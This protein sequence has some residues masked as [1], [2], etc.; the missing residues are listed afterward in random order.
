MERRATFIAIL[1]IFAAVAICY[2]STLSAGFIWD[3]QFLIE[4]NPILRAPLSSLYIFKQ[5]IANSSGAFTIYYRPLQ[6]LSYAIDYRTWGI[7]PFGF[8]LT[9]ILL[10]FLN[11]VCT[12]FL[13]KKLT[14]RNPIALLTAIFFA[15]HPAHAGVVSY[16]SG[17]ADLLLFLFAF[18]SILCFVL[19]RERKKTAYLAGSTLFFVAALLSK[20]IALI[21]PILI[22]LTDLVLLRRT[23]NNR[24][25]CHVPL[26]LVAI[27]YATCHHYFFGNRY[28]TLIGY[29]AFLQN[30]GDYLRMLKE[31]FTLGII[32][33]GSYMR[34]S[35]SDTGNMLT[36]Y[37]AIGTS[38]SILIYCLKNNRKQ[39]AYSLA[40]FFI[41]L[42]PLFFVVH[43]FRV[44]ADHWMYV[45]S[46]G[47]FFF[48]ALA[49]RG[50]YKSS[51]NFGKVFA[52]S[53]ITIGVFTF[54]IVTIQQNE[55]WREDSSLS[56]RI[57]EHS[58]EDRAALHYKAVST[59][60]KGEEKQ[61]LEIAAR[62]AELNRHDPMPWYTKGRLE[63]AADNIK[64]ART[65]FQTAIGINPSYANGYLGLAFVS[66]AQKNNKKGIN[67]LKK[68]LKINPSHREALMLL[69]A[70]Y[71]S[72]ED[73]QKA[74]KTA[75]RAK[76][77]NPYDYN[78][79]LNLGT[80]YTRL[81]KTQEGA[82]QYLEA[83]Q[84]YP[85][86][87]VAYYNLAYLFHESE[88]DTEAI[89]YLHKALKNDPNF[90]PAF[91]LLNEIQNN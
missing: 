73:Y 84:L 16:I 2:T 13:T 15:V 28:G 19:F 82:R 3:D 63:F 5:D 77:V 22:L 26:F 69:T 32:P 42:L 85:K 36:F 18:L 14:G 40:F 64:E 89:D 91:D 81:G 83:T 20:E 76:V 86:K 46:Y 75:L 41:S 31:F 45:A 70:T 9:S 49:I 65:D 51:G 43:Y 67:Y 27:S 59:F 25:W 44:F 80:T 37:I 72:M 56:D 58:G 61:A 29:S 87:T 33:L 78:V 8:H 79:L 1:L 71:I 6:M 4:R 53:L 21:I 11:A 90:K 17:R 7:N 34:R 38:I 47:L 35:V 66:F 39:I 88:M 74:L 52:V 24:S 57:L 30:L 60:R 12:F 55:Y 62:Y 50:L 23:R 68:A 10:H 48:E 54:S